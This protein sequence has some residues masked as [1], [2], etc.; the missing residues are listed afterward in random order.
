[1]EASVKQAL[2]PLRVIWVQRIP[3]IAPTC[4][5]RTCRPQI[6]L[7]HFRVTVELQPNPHLDSTAPTVVEMDKGVD[8]VVEILPAVVIVLA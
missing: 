8:W 4:N 3:A 2:V 1:M 7:V 6:D 5:Y